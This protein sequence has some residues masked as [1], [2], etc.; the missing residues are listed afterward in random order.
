M[1]R[2]MTVLI[3][4]FICAGLGGGFGYIVG[5]VNWDRTEFGK[6][7]GGQLR[8]I[9]LFTCITLVITTVLTLTSI[10]ERPLLQS[11]KRSSKH[12]KSPILHLPPSPPP[13]AGAL[14][15]AE[16]EEEGQYQFSGRRYRDCMGHSCSANARLCAGLTSPISPFSPLTPKYGSF[17]SRD[18][19]LTD[20]NEF[21]SSLGTS[22]IDSVL[23][24]CYTG[25][26]MPQPLKPETTTPFLPM[27][28]TPLA[29]VSQLVEA[30]SP[31]ADS[32]E[33]ESS[34][35]NGELQEAERLEGIDE[36]QAS[37]CLELNEASELSEALQDGGGLKEGSSTSGILKR[38]Q[39]LALIDEPLI[40]PS[41]GLENGR[42]RT[43]TFSQQ[44]NF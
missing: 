24:D 26:H 14:Q 37:E 6:A 32:Q 31:A 28:E 43:V 36:A 15:Q 34:Q 42:R 33:R 10:P 2:F 5:G 12:L 9:Y 30:P 18:N 41:N 39:S 44:V 8:V 13:P 38:P 22:Y 40:G 4:H 16:E 27:G 21:A 17:I 1:G 3:I 29:Q 20:I 25:Q 11:Q 23:I 7:M 19:T 35:P